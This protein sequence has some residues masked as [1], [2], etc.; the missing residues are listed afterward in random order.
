MWNADGSPAPSIFVLDNL[1]KL[2]SSPE[3][4]LPPAPQR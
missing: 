1:T 3:S 4:R 2:M